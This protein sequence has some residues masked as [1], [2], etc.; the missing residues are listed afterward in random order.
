M[1]IKEEKPVT[2]SEVYD[3]VSNNEKSEEIKKFLSNFKPLKLEKALEL[4]KELE[5]LD[6][7]KLK[8]AHIVKIVDFLPTDL[9]ELNKVLSDVSLDETESNKI[10][11][12]VKNY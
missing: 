6:L 3:L 11:D 7:I 10:L 1:V 2:L 8:E 9:V 12:V 5:A 4:K